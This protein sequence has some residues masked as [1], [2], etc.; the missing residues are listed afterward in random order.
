MIEQ[1]SKLQQKKNVAYITVLNWLRDVQH[2]YGMLTFYNPQVISKLIHIYLFK[3]LSAK[4]RPGTLY[5]GSI[6]MQ[7]GRP[8]N[9]V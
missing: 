5:L 9:I 4:I 6:I 2:I 7:V 8:L 3:H 1:Q